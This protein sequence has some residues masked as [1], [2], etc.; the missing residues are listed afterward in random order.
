MASKTF[1]VRLDPNVHD[2]VKKVARARGE[3]M[4]TFIRRAVLREL[5]NLNFLDEEQR[6]I[7]RERI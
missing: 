5:A 4:S 2:L 3:T 1:L 7:L 6:R